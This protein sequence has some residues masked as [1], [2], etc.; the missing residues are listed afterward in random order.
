[1]TASNVLLLETICTQ[2]GTMFE[3]GLYSDVAVCI[4]QKSTLKLHRNILACRSNF[5]K[6]RFENDDQSAVQRSVVLDIADG[7]TLEAT[8]AVLKYLYKGGIQ[9]TKQN[10]TSVLAVANQFQADELMEMCGKFLIKTVNIDNACSIL[11]ISAKYSSV[12]NSLADK[13]LDLILRKGG[14]AIQTS[15]FLLLSK[16]CIIQLLSSELFTLDSR[17]Q[18][19]QVFLRLQA[20]AEANK[21][22]ETLS[23]TMADFIPHIIFCEMEHAFLQK[24]VRTSGC[25]PIEVICDA[26]MEKADRAANDPT[27]RAFDCEDDSARPRKMRKLSQQLKQVKPEPGLSD[28]KL[29]IDTI[30]RV[31]RNSILFTTNYGVETVVIDL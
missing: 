15:G 22:C 14:Q 17:L 25:V 19:Q 5:F 2:F 7:A 30:Q 24:T 16:H 8:E 12:F 9:L 31:T 18:E 11:A 26:M 23:D 13:C 10:V 21:G 4:A 3:K 1:M 27:K 20:W 6:Q 29:D 28:D